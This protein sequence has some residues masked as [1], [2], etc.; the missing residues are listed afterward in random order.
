MLHGH[1]FNFLSINLEKLHN[2]PKIGGLTTIKSL[3]SR[4]PETRKVP[5][6]FDL[7][8]MLV[9]DATINSNSNFIFLNFSKNLC[10]NPYENIEYF[11]KCSV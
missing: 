3:F 4:K 11:G 10:V 5:N 8:H 1:R 2:T 6:L 9:N 7:H